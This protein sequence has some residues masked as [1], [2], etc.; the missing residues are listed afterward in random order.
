M[1]LSQLE[2]A[3]VW[4]K[5]WRSSVCWRGTCSRKDFGWKEEWDFKN[6]AKSPVCM[7][8][9]KCRRRAAA[10]Q[11]GSLRDTQCVGCVFISKNLTCNTQMKGPVS[12]Q[13]SS[14]KCWSLVC[15]LERAH[16]EGFFQGFTALRVPLASKGGTKFFFGCNYRKQLPAFLR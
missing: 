16:R 7:T 6:E 2:E 14:H 11:G 15:A 1:G 4:G 9:Q 13:V 5:V 10:G 12:L 8:W 3:E